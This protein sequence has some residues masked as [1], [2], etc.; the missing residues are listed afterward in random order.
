MNRRQALRLSGMALAA[1]RVLPQAPKQAVAPP[2]STPTVLLDD[3]RPVS[4][5][6]IQ[7]TDIRKA[8]FPVFHAH[9]HGYR[10]FDSV[11]GMVKVMDSLN[12]E[13]TVIM[14]G[15]STPER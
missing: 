6:K 5:Y 9:S 8:K 2:G 13:R 10:N 7:V 12:I 1:H 3:Y 15:G 14:T 4:L 11:D